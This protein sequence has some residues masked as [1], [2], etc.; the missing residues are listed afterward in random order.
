MSNAILLA[1]KN[2]VQSFD[3][4][5]KDVWFQRTTVTPDFTGKT[6]CISRVRQD[7]FTHT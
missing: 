2:F 3:S 1:N 7:H 5:T 4:S 6:E